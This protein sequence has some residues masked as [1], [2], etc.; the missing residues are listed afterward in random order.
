MMTEQEIN[1][2]IEALV[3]KYG[4]KSEGRYRMWIV[5]LSDEPQ[6]PDDASQKSPAHQWDAGTP[7]TAKRIVDHFVAKGMTEFQ[8]G[9]G[10]YV[11]VR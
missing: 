10:R 7:E 3:A 1:T 11:C 4:A 8:Q 5:Q 6:M 9:S 2:E